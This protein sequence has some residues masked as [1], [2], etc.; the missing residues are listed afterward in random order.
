MWAASCPRKPAVGFLT[1]CIFPGTL[2]YF[3]R[4]TGLDQPAQHKRIMLGRK[5]AHA[6]SQPT[7]CVATCPHARFK[8]HTTH[9]Q[10]Q[11]V[12]FAMALLI[13]AL[14]FFS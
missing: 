14:V 11:A 6:P 2:V 5:Q 4:C 7:P 1:Y 12:V 8:N 13:E 9:P 3:D 10:H